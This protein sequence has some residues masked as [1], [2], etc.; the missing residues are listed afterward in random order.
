MLVQIGSCKLY[1]KFYIH[2]DEF[3]DFSNCGEQPSVFSN[4]LRMV[5]ASDTLGRQVEDFCGTAKCGH[6]KLILWCKPI[7]KKQ[8]NFQVMEIM[9]SNYLNSLLTLSQY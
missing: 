4:Y 2:R 8:K 6:P 7:R 1:G 3:P 5:N 9:K